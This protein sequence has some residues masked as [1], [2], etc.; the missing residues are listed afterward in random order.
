MILYLC[1][2]IK[3]SCLNLI[4]THYTLQNDAILL[5]LEIVQNIVLKFCAMLVRIHTFDVIIQLT[6]S[7]VKM[8]IQKNTK[9][10]FIIIS[11]N[12]RKNCLV[13]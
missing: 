10:F 6:S 8:V 5:V 3:S 7:I 4:F 9:L 12:M 13:I 1:K 2:R 11:L